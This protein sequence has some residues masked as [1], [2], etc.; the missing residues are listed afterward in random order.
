MSD[1]MNKEFFEG[2]KVLI[3]GLGRFGGGV[4]AAE[5][6]CNAG[7]KVTVTDLAEAEQ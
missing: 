2:K 5:F 4:D 3:M 6:A 1:G 7:A